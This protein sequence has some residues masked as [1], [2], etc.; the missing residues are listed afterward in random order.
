M[1]SHTDVAGALHVGA[2]VVSGE[3]GRVAIARGATSCT[4]TSRSVGAT[5]AV[6]AGTAESCGQTT[7]T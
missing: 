4:I 7:S 5:G 2:A 3:A 6:L 1:T